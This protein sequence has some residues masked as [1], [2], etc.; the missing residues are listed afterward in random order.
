MRNDIAA[1]FETLNTMMENN[2]LVVVLIHIWKDNIQY[3]ADFTVLSSTN[4]HH[5][6]IIGDFNAP[7][8]HRGC[9][10]T[11]P[12]RQVTEE[13]QS[14]QLARSLVMQPD[15]LVLCLPHNL[16]T[17]SYSTITLAAVNQPGSKKD[18]WQLWVWCDTQ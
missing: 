7:I 10:R 5:N 2:K 3:F 1:G 6:I 17:P 16:T 9:A 12:M 18:T 4:I 8:S 11:I 15:Q 14:R 13:C